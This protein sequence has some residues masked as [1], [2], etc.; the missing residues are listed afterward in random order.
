ME[1]AQPEAIVQQKPKRLTAVSFAPVR[2]VTD[3]DATGVVNILGNTVTLTNGAN[4]WS[5]TNISAGATLQVGDGSA[6]GALLG[7]VPA[8]PDEPAFPDGRAT[9]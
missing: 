1:I 5:A 4:N 8:V 2:T 7:N 9:F 6:A 3:T